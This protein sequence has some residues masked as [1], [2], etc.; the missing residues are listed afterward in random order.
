MFTND[1]IPS[2][3]FY[4]DDFRVVDYQGD[5]LSLNDWDT[6]LDLSIYPN[7]A[8]SEVHIRLSEIPET[9]LQVSIVDLQGRTVMPN[10]P[11][12]QQQTT[13]SVSHLAPG[14]YFVSLGGLE[15]R[16]VFKLMIE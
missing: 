10:R 6:G 15:S 4:F 8:K 2:D 11:M 16:Q 3:G 9:S 7:P 13:L 1:F 12:T 14:L 5:V